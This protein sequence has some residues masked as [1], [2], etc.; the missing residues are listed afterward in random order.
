[1]EGSRPNCPFAE[2]LGSIGVPLGL[3]RKCHVYI[4]FWMKHLQKKI[5]EKPMK[6]I[7]MRMI[8]K[9]IATGGEA[10]V[11]GDGGGGVEFWT[12]FEDI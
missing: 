11:V 4:R 8:V 9:I 12:E 1:M 3:F 2:T 5:E 6:K 10:Y 7:K